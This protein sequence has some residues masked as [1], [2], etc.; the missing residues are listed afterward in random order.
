MNNLNDLDRVAKSITELKEKVPLVQCITNYVT[1]NDCANIL[2]A[3]GA[4]PAMCEAYDE[5]FNFVKL[6]SALYINVGT[7]TKEQ[8]EAAVLA[9][10]SAKMNNI[11]VVL[12]PVACG[13]IPRKLS[14]INRIFELGRVDII[15]GN[16]GEIKFLAGEASKVRGVDSLENSEGA[17]ESCI[18]LANKLNCVVVATGKEDFIT[19]GKRSAAIQN[20]TEMLTKV[21]G[22]GCML[23]ALCG[24]MAGS[25]ED[26]FIAAVA[27]V[28]S[29]NIAGEGAYEEAKVPGTFKVKLMDHIYCLSEEKLKEEGK[30]IWK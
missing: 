3:F 11:P 7:L 4:S 17:L 27:A 23:G 13:A 29:M 19:D 2:L 21:T 24:G 6:S 25:C 20:G 15:K 16:I 30:V 18:R 26:K 22:S 8:E 12:D 14:V 28:L 9:S 10:I 1:I 5:V